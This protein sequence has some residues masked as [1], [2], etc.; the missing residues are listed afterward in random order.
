MTP[1]Q[2]IAHLH[3]ISVGDVAGLRAKLEQARLACVALEQADLADKVVE[4][5]H[6]LDAADLKTFRKRIETVVARLG[7]LR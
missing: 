6:A 5:G 7:H 3:S 1:A 4:A 2:L